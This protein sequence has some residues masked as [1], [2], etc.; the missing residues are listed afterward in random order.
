MAEHQHQPV[1]YRT[2]VLT[3]AALG[4]L[5]V[6]TVAAS[7]VDIG[8]GHVWVALGIASAKS[9]LVISIF[10][11]LRQ[12]SKLFKIGLLAMLLILAIFI[13]MTFLDVLY[14]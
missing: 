12:E 10:M 13:G 6:L 8:A 3:W 7:R 11:N 4:L 2:L 5:T 14:R 1:R 9:F